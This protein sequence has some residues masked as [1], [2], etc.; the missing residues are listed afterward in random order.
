MRRPN[1]LL[2]MALLAAVSG[3]TLGDGIA[4][5]LVVMIVVGAVLSA[6]FWALV[7]HSEIRRRHF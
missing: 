2:A 1:P 4:Y 5:R 6:A 3:T 7:I